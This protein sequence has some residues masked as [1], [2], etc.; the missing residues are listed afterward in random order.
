MPNCISVSTCPAATLAQKQAVLKDAKTLYDWS[1][2]NLAQAAETYALAL[3]AN[4]K[5][6][7][8]AQTQGA[9]VYEAVRAGDQVAVAQYREFF[10]LMQGSKM[11]TRPWPDSHPLFNPERPAANAKADTAPAPRK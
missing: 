8:A 1:T 6:Q 5:W 2:A 9:A 3:A 10:Q 11:P 7:D 4:G